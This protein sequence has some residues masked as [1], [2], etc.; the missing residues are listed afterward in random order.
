M[1][2][3]HLVGAGV[4]AAVLATAL[5][6]PVAAEPGLTDARARAAELRVHL[7][8]LERQVATATEDYNAAQARL[9]AAVTAHLLA[10]RRLHDLEQARVTDSGAAADR[11]RALYMSGGGAGLYA[12][13]LEGVL[14]G[15]DIGDAMVRF[16]AVE[17]LLGAD[18]AVL[19][20][21]ATTAH[22]ASTQALELARR[23]GEQTRLQ[24]RA[25]AAAQRVR[26]LLAR[27]RGLLVA[28]DAEVR[29]LAE[30]AR[31]AAQ[32]R[33]ARA[34]A[35]RFAAGPELAPGTSYA[36]GAIRAA[37]TRLGA[38]Y[39]W[40]AT[41]PDTFDCSGLTG[42]AYAAAGLTLPR[43]SRQQWYAGRRVADADL[44]PGD[45]VFWAS[46]TSNPATIHHMGLYV[47]GGRMIHAP[48]TGEV[49]ELAPL[50]LDGYIGAVR[51]GAPSA[52][53]DT[54]G[55]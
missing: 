38:P 23:A 33:A 7:D 45:L 47:G 14:E 16:E 54:P 51:P 49:V 31:L 35:A 9:G 4:L 39:V 37:R 10:E 21:S 8:A 32:A 44:R 12:S 34:A 42:W 2:P 50:W 52:V 25:E 1:R 36:A 27:T 19:D 13:V 22:Q 17:S 55:R 29:R 24:Q 6:G 40:G 41:G 30:R 20:Q 3:L 11:V 43:T 46:D 18:L 5:S 48:R 53:S 26:A 28:A 15:G